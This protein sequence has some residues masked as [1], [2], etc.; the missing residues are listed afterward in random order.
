M[1]FYTKFTVAFPEGEISAEG[2]HEISQ[3]IAQQDMLSGEWKRLNPN[4]QGSYLPALPNDWLWVWLIQRGEYAGTMPKRVSSYYWK[5]HGVKCPEQFLAQLG[6]IARAHSDESRTYHFEFVSRINWEAGDFGDDGSCFWGG[7]A[8]AKVMIEENG[9]M[10]IRFY[11]DAGDGYARAWVVEIE[12]DFL[13]V[14]NG[15]GLTTLQIARV[16][17]QF[18]GLSYQLIHLTN[19]PGHELYIN[20]GK[21]YAVGR[22][23]F[24]S[25]IE[26]WNLGWDDVHAQVCYDCER[27][28]GEDDYYRGAD[29]E[30][31]C[32]DCFYDRFRDCAHCGEP[33]Y[34]D[35]LTIVADG[36]GDVCETCLDRYYALCPRCD[37]Y[38]LTRNMT[39]FGDTLC[40][41][42][43]SE[44]L[45][46]EGDNIE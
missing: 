39:R 29:D 42:T 38:W 10:A 44:E 8:G 46:I 45:R 41:Q 6:N 17:A 33:E 18:M 15:Y 32:Q 37:E 36:D 28:L 11:D 12:V 14:F 9:G 24:I 23:D 35:E 4:F 40:C 43:C 16:L 5:K 21:G 27:T 34:L 20:S 25:T 26:E 1:E 30:I 31:Y 19:H 7:H 22:S 2:Q 3:Y 13:I